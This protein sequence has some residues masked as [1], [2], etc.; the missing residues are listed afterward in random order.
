[1]WRANR[2]RVIVST[3]DAVKREDFSVVSVA[4]EVLNFG[5]QVVKIPGAAVWREA[6][7]CA[8]ERS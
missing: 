8:V 2:E 1:M 6:R 3:A 4:R 5:G 7:R